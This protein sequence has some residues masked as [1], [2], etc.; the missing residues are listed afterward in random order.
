MSRIGKKPIEV[1]PGVE[2]KT[3][4]QVVSA[5][6][7]KGKLQYVVHPEVQVK[8]KN[9]RLLC[10]VKSGGRKASALWGTTRSRLANMIEGVSRGYSKQLE[11]RGVGYR[12]AL[13]GG[14]LE[15]EVGYS[16][17]VLVEAPAGITFSVEKEII[18]VEGVDKV[19]VGQAAADIRRVRK[20][21]P[22]QG[23]GIRY[24]GEQVRRKAGKVVGAAA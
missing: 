15:L 20:P 9:D 22:Y 13:K 8:L 3:A 17:R 2:V 10:E 23:K 12:A 18:T 1:P 6:G 14:N 11:L 4:G 7:P 19:L 24:R 21:E 16:H 5:D